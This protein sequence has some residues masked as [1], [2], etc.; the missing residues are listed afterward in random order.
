MARMVV[1][2]L[3]PEE[4]AGLTGFRPS[5]ISRI[6]GTPAFQ[7][8]VNR[9]EAMMEEDGMDIH[10]EIRTLAENAVE[11]LSQNINAQAVSD[12]DKNRQQKAAFDI[13]DRA[14]F[15][16][17]ETHVSKNLHLHAD[18]KDVRKLTTEQLQEDISDLLES[19]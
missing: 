1:E 10:K 4:I 6:L 16:K 2:G 11:V 3:R 7:A 17:T 8:E 15:G 14:G 12:A 9:I 13:L 19:E 18:I 5:H